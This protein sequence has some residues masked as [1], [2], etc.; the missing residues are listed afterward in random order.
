MK[1]ET[2]QY[3]ISLLVLIIVAISHIMLIALYLHIVECFYI[4]LLTLIP[5]WC[6]P[7]F[8]QLLFFSNAKTKAAYP[9]LTL[10]LTNVFHATIFGFMHVHTIDPSCN[11]HQISDFLAMYPLINMSLIVPTT[12][13]IAIFLIIGAK[14]PEYQTVNELAPI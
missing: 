7:I 8:A 10:L 5:V 2:R 4:M 11:T 9:Y 13:A 1:I 12:F 14:Q 3:I 6:I